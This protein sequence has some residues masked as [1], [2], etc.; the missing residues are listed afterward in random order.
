[1]KEAPGHS[2]RLQRE[3]PD[4]VL[5]PQGDDDPPVSIAVARPAHALF[6]I[7]LRYLHHGL[8]KRHGSQHVALTP[9]P[10]RFPFSPPLPFS[11]PLSCSPS[12]SSPSGAP[13]SIKT[14]QV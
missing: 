9:P 13:L 1:M 10:S 3:L 11:L 8:D 5:R 2:Q 4:K 6:C 14:S 7:P 12:P